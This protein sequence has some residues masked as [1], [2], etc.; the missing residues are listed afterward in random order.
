MRV[1]LTLTSWQMRKARLIDF[2]LACAAWIILM[3][4]YVALDAAVR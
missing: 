4:V 2:G 3:G 1:S